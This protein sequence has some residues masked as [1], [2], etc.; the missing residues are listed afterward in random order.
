MR[1]TS[2]HHAHH[3][4][5][6]SRMARSDFWLFELSVWFHALALSLV[7]IF[8]PILLYKTGFSISEIILYYF[9]FNLF[10]VP[11]NFAASA[12]TRHIGARAVA[13]IGTFAAILFIISLLNLHT[14]GAYVCNLVIMAIFAALY[15][16]MYWVAHLYLF[17]QSDTDI[18]HTS[19]NT[20]V[21]YAVR[22]TAITIGPII[23]AAILLFF[24]EQILLFMVII[25]FLISIV[26]L[27]VMHHPSNKPA[28]KLLLHDFF[29]HLGVRRTYLSK[30]FYNFHNEVE[31]TLFPL[32]IF[33]L[34]GTIQSVAAIPLIASLAA[35]I[36]ALS[37]G[38]VPHEHR[39]RTIITGAILI[40]ITWVGRIFLLHSVFL[41]ASVLLVGVFSYLVLVPLDSDIF[42]NARKNGDP[43]SASM[44]RNVV[45]MSANTVL[46]GTLLLVTNVFPAS[47]A[48]AVTGL[49]VLILANIFL[50]RKTITVP[51]IPENIA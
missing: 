49:T 26:P 25:F 4:R 39:R 17:I 24:N 38:T 27:S 14:S 9:L 8:I 35:I 51:P 19:K 31:T 3:I 7:S 18:D 13:I 44:Y 36:I 47:M 12:L 16:T 20:G 41:Y 11:L 37:L 29:E 21:F 5:A 33:T 48:I 46:Y 43:L 34:F 28:K 42:E 50:H 40:A 30:M 23:G 32:F 10:D 1:T 22:Q 15:D 6:Y 45:D 2:I